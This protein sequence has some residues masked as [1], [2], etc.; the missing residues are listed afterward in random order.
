MS[1]LDHA[2]FEAY[3]LRDGGVMNETVRVVLAI[4]VPLAVL[5]LYVVGWRRT[6]RSVRRKR[7][8]YRQ[9]PDEFPSR[10]SRILRVLPFG[11]LTAALTVWFAAS[12]R[13]DNVPLGVV[14]TACFAFLI[15]R[16]ATGSEDMPE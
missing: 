3:S 1:A 10:R 14:G 9:H 15:Y 5:G 8:Y 16:I 13:T 4:A 11:L 12:G 6:N 2:A 7:E